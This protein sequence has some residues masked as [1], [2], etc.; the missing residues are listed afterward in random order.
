[1]NYDINIPENDP[2]ECEICGMDIPMSCCVL[3]GRWMCR[4]CEA[5]IP[6]DEDTDGP[7]CEEC[8]E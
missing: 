2:E 7:I 8:F 3:C 4:D 6:E 5:E 1:M